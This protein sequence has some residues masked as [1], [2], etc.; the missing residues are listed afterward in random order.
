MM[1]SHRYARPALLLL[2]AGLC[3]ARQAESAAPAA[4]TL[5]RLFTTPAERAALDQRRRNG[6][7]PPAP[8]ATA[9]PSPAPAPP[10]P[11]ITL[12][13]VVRPSS[14]APTIWLNDMPQTVHRNML[15]DGR[16]PSG[17]VSVETPNGKRLTL[18]P[19]QSYDMGSGSIRDSDG[20]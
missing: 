15:K 17:A 16:T 4:P 13:G 9:Q 14:G 8:V 5:G 7:A 3:A 12:D 2:L 6:N 1:V 11:L 19:G 20:D 10:L 18:K